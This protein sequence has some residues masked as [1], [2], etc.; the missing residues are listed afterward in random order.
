MMSRIEIMLKTKRKN[1]HLP[2]MGIN[3]HVYKT[4]QKTKM[5]MLLITQNSKLMIKNFWLLFQRFFLQQQ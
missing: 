1:N 2:E 4:I 5:L 3:H